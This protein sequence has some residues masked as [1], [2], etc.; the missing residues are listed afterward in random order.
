MQES[1]SPS[2]EVLGALAARLL[3]EAP[4]QES[5]RKGTGGGDDSGGPPDKW[6]Q[7]YL[8]SLLAAIA[9]YGPYSQQELT[10]ARRIFCK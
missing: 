1:L 7:C 10:Q 9:Q 3:A 8:A 2:Q 6:Q 4:G 5:P